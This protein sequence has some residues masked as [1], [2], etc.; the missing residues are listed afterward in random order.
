MRPAQIS[1]P[2]QCTWYAQAYRLLVVLGM[3]MIYALAGIPALLSGERC[4]RNDIDH[5]LNNT[6][7]LSVWVPRCQ[8]LTDTA[9]WCYLL[10]GAA[11]IKSLLLQKLA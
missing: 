8:G 4:C 5:A 11:A 3:M 9:K 6:E 2:Q 10:A 7:V 1:D